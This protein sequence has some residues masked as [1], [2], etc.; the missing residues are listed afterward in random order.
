MA[1]FS[2]RVRRFAPRPKAS[3]LLVCV[4]IAS[5]SVSLSAASSA[6]ALS[7]STTNSKYFAGYVATATNS[8]NDAV[9]VSFDVPTLSCAQQTR[10]KSSPYSSF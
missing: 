6:E 4:A 3:I 9:Q 2:R 7:S 1:Y 10:T 8:S 5:T